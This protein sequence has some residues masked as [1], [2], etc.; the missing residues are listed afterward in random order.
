MCAFADVN[1]A[2]F[3]AVLIAA[4]NTPLASPAITAEITLTRDAT[5]LLAPFTVSIAVRNPTTRPVGVDFPTADMYRIDV[6]H[7]DAI[8]W[9]TATGHKPLLITRRVDIAPGL[10]RLAS[11][12]VDGTTDDRR[13]YPTGSSIVHVAMQGKTLTTAIDRPLVFDP[14]LSIADARALP[15]GTVVTIAGVPQSASDTSTLL[16]ATG[17]ITL[18]RPLGLH[19]TGTY[20]VRGVVETIGAN[21]QFAV[22]RLAPAFDNDAAARAKPPTT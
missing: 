14:P 18:S 15:H 2:D 20:V 21:V 1:R 3:V 7:D 10:T 4:A 6:V 5:A 8:V 11:Q 12:I 17:S 19:P 9:S 13:A 22:A 16:D